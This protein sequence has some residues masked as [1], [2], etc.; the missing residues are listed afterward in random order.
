MRWKKFLKYAH[1]QKN[2]DESFTYVI[3]SL[4][5]NYRYHVYRLHYILIRMPPEMHSR[6]VRCMP[7]HRITELRK[8]ISSTQLAR[9]HT[10]SLGGQCHRK[11]VCNHLSRVT[12]TDTSGAVNDRF[13]HAKATKKKKK[14]LVQNQ[15]AILRHAKDP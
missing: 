12:T 3:R 15:L 13:S 1:V 7:L 2:T 5:L 8:R 9:V 10:L 14:S 11:P 4:R 6:S